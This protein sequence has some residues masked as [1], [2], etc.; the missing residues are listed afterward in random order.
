MTDTNGAAGI[1]AFGQGLELRHLAGAFE[2]PHVAVQQSD[3][4]RVI[5]AIF[6]AM[7]AFD[8]DRVGV[9]CPRYA[10][11]RTWAGIFTG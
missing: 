4:G 6:E 11:I 9:R 10:T 2:D 8:N 1:L 7:Q 3:T 5:T